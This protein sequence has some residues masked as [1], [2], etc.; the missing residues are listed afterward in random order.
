VFLSP[1]L[2][3]ICAINKIPFAFQKLEGKALLLMNHSPEHT[4]TGVMKLKDGNIRAKFLPKNTTAH[5]I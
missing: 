2:K 5:K 1:G 4:V 3:M